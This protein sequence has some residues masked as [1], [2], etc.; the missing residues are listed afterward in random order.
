MEYIQKSVKVQSGMTNINV[1]CAF[2]F[3]VFFGY[4]SYNTSSYGQPPPPPH[5]IGMN[6]VI[7]F[8]HSNGTDTCSAKLLQEKIKGFPILILDELCHKI[9][10]SFREQKGKYIY[11]QNWAVLI[12]F[13]CYNAVN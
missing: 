8:F 13:P 12:W 9:V 5:S 10:P 2:W 11:S 1:S 6:I 4:A 7:Y 3:L